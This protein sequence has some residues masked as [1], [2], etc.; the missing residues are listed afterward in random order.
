MADK[1]TPEVT[2][3]VQEEKKKLIAVED[4][5]KDEDS[6]YAYSS[7]AVNF[8]LV[9]A[10]ENGKRKQATRLSTC[11]D[12]LNDSI[13][14][15][16]H[17]DRVGGCSLYMYG[18]YPPIDMNKMRLLIV[19]GSGGDS[20]KVNTKIRN[21]VFSGKAAINLYEGIAGWEKSKITTVNHSKVGKQ[22]WLM[23]GPGNWMKASN[24]LSMVTLIIRVAANNGPLKVDSLE[25]LNAHWKKMIEGE[26]YGVYSDKHYLK[27]CHDKFELIM[28]HCD[29]IFCDSLE[30]NYPGEDYE[31]SFHSGGGINA[32]C[33]FSTH[34]GDIDE[35]FQEIYTKHFEK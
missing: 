26:S 25:E 35:R 18:K 9:A 4:I 19:R 28:R 31:G 21:K 14:G 7:T 2:E 24:L 33:T 5:I 1:E 17:K 29:E 30:E 20:K 16:I 6:Y 3:D 27:N 10:P 8:A 11:R 22:A 15:H 23:T 12:Y 32:L 34:I 13:R